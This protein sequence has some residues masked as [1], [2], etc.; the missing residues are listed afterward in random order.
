MQLLPDE[1]IG[2]VLLTNKNGTKLH[3]AIAMEVTDMLLNKEDDID[4]VARAYP[5]LPE[6]DE[7]NAE[8]DDR[9]KKNT[10]PSLPLVDYAGEYQHPGYGSIFIKHRS[11]NLSYGFNSFQAPLEHYHFDV[12]EGEL[13]DL[14]QQIKLQFHMD[15]E[16]NIIG[17]STIVE[18]S[19]DP[20]MFK[21]LAPKQVDDP[22]FIVAVEGEYTLETQLI[23]I[24]KS[25]DNL[26]LKIT[27]QPEYTLVP[28]QKDEFKIEGLPGFSVKFFFNQSR[29]EVKELVFYQP[30]GVFTATKN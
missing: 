30:N 23:D 28:Y 25:G 10:R 2:M 29:D 5:E 15:I 7:D 4:W 22:R 13:N 6:E 17:L 20:I 8:S 9:R 3:N 16:G 19:L 27:G 14:D 11:G 26:K 18:P 21:K 24:R 1:E 12:F